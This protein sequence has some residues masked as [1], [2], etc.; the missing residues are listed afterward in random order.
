MISRHHRSSIIPSSLVSC[1]A[2]FWIV[3][4]IFHAQLEAINSERNAPAKF[5]RCLADNPVWWEGL[6]IIIKRPAEFQNPLITVIER[7]LRWLWLRLCSSMPRWL[8]AT[9]IILFP[10]ADLIDWIELNFNSSSLVYSLMCRVMMERNYR[11]FQIWLYGFSTVITDFS[12]VINQNE[13]LT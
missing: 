3:Q 8:S 12:L 7:R 9:I 1:G 6:A 11:L 4:T 5:R 10:S 2:H 13:K